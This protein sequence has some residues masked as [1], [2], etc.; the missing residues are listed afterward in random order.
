MP[1]K[2]LAVARL[3][4]LLG[5]ATRLAGF[6][7]RVATKTECSMRDHDQPQ[8]LTVGCDDVPENGTSFFSAES[9]KRAL[10]L[11]RM[12]RF[13][14]VVTRSELADG[15]AL[16][17]I[18]KMRTAWPWQKWAL[19][20]GDCSVHDEITARTLGVTR[21]FEADVNW[22]E[23][24]LLAGSLRRRASVAASTL[25]GRSVALRV[26]ETASAT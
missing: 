25:A 21:I 22:D 6:T 17:L 4:L 11:L 1:K 19:V 13:D 16:N 14:L 5:I 15:P 18:Q 2:I 9:G 20:A 3:S 23:V 24:T 26:P 10:E 8:V 12:L 7:A